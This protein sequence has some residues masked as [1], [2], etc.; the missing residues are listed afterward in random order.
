[1]VV[2]IEISGDKKIMQYLINLPKKLDNSLIRTNEQ[3]MKD[4]RKSAKLRAPKDTSETSKSIQIKKTIT[5]GRKKQWK[6]VV[7]SRAAIYQELGFKPHWAYIKGSR[8]LKDGM[9][10]V[11]KSKPFLA[12][13][14]DAQLAK[15]DQKINKSVDMSL[16]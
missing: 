16:K 6:L 4:V 9:Y 7:N 5:R 1:M 12:P 8:K 13:A 14:I 3:F 15:F 10:F 2:R 11:S